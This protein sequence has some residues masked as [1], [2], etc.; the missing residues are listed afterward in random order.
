MTHV[1]EVALAGLIKLVPIG[2]HD[3]LA[4]PLLW[5]LMSSLYTD[6][7]QTHTPPI[8]IPT[9]TQTSS[10]SH[11]HNYTKTCS[12]RASYDTQTVRVRESEQEG[13]R[14]RERD[15]AW[16]CPTR[17]RDSEGS[18]AIMLLPGFSLLRKLPAPVALFASAALRIASVHIQ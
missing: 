2:T 17:T 9:S 8:P 12:V 3:V 14:E 4:D 10:L 18:K 1:G 11:T 6:T 5:L 16:G 15:L 13:E 7:D